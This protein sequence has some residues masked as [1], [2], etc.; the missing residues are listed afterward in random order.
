MALPELPVSAIPLA[1]DAPQMHAGKSDSGRTRPI[2]AL[3][4]TVASIENGADAQG[5]LERLYGL[6]DRADS[7]FEEPPKAAPIQ[8]KAL[9]PDSGTGLRRPVELRLEGKGLAIQ[10]LEG[11]QKGI[12]SSA[13]YFR[14]NRG[15]DDLLE[16][17]LDLL[18]S[19]IKI[20]PRMWGNDKKTAYIAAKKSFARLLLNDPEL[21]WESLEKGIL[22]WHEPR[23]WLQ[24]VI[25]PSAAMRVFFAML[26]PVLMAWW[27]ATQSIRL[28][29]ELGHYA[30]ARSLGAEVLRFRVFPSGA[31]GLVTHSPVAPA[32]D[33]LI[34][35]AGPLLQMA[36]GG[37]LFYLAASSGSGLRIKLLEAVP[38][39]IG[40]LC[41]IIESGSDW[42]DALSLIRD[43]ERRP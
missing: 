38:G 4:R 6:G 33:A 7:S 24:S 29:H 28:V 23:L 3:K 37:F 30:A 22:S 34:A 2:D 1:L 15:E 8:N 18:N 16:S 12:A 5:K 26:L 10:I 42:S 21:R 32:K 20:A 36:A 41:S 13:A 9:I 31:G 39:L 25:P 35:L 43:P 17:T 14:R 19:A 27:T 11:G 40:I